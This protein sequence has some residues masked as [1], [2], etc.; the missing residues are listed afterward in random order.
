MP[1]NLEMLFSEMY[2]LKIPRRWEGWGVFPVDINN[3]N[4]SYKAISYFR[5]FFYTPPL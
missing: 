2:I 4:V 5:V 1:N 3:A